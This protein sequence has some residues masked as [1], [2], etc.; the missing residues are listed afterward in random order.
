M[1]LFT[2]IVSLVSLIWAAHSITL[3]VTS[4]FLAIAFLFSGICVI[5]YKNLPISFLLSWYLIWIPLFAAH[6]RYLGIEYLNQVGFILRIGATQL[7]LI[8][9]LFIAFYSFFLNQRAEKSQF[10]RIDF[11]FTLFISWIVLGY[12]FQNDLSDIITKRFYGWITYYLMIYVIGRIWITNKQELKWMLQSSVLS[13]LMVVISR[14][15]YQSPLSFLDSYYRLEVNYIYLSAVIYSQILVLIVPSAFYFFKYQK[16]YK[17]VFII[18]FILIFLETLFSQTR[19]AYIAIF[20]Y[21]IIYYLNETKG[22]SNRWKK[23]FLLLLVGVIFFI[24]VFF[25]LNLREE[26]HG[27]NE[28]SSDYRL[29]MMGYYLEEIL[30]NIFT[31][32]GYGSEG[33]KGIFIEGAHNTYLGIL[34]DAGIIGLSIFLALVYSIYNALK[35]NIQDHEMKQY[36]VVIKY[37]L[38]TQVIHWMFTGNNL[39]YSIPMQIMFFVIL[40]VVSVPTIC[41]KN[42]LGMGLD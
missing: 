17:P 13:M 32:Y 41:Q 36:A 8:I 9:C 1:K 15:F 7:A 42:N 33:A 29:L 19:G 31:G 5:K 30:K 3:N 26:A 23:I 24:L 11:I 34:Y 4:I 18:A 2:I 12:Y 38:L 6:D 10:S 25:L 39:F 22:Y 21:I 28:G 35:K 27:S 16:T 40:F 20:I 37:G 14:Y